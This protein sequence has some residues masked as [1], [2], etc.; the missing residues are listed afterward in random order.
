VFGEQCPEVY[1]I[2][3][4][5][6]DP[7]KLEANDEVDLSGG[8]VAFEPLQLRAILVLRTL[9]GVHVELRRIDLEVLPSLPKFHFLLNLVLL[10]KERIPLVDLSLR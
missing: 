10:G 8:N 5:P 9:A 3:Q 4:A 7:I 1:E 6:G 2:L